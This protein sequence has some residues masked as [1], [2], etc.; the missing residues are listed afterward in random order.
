M[1][2]PLAPFFDEVVAGSM[3]VRD[4]VLTGYLA[5]PPL[6]DEARASWLREYA[7]VNG[8]NLSQ[9]YGYGDSHAD[10]PWLQLVGNPTAVNPD[11]QLYSHAQAKRWTIQPWTTKGK[12]ATPSAPN[13][14]VT[15]DENEKA[16]THG[17]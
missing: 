9:S 7:K 17:L 8:F 15:P 2:T 16:V 14:S 10:V 4:G 3:H 1:T 11:T 13:A 6:V 5:T 12:L